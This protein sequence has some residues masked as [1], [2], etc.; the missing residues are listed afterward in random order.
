LTAAGSAT[1]SVS[2]ATGS[3]VAMDALATSLTIATVSEEFAFTA[4]KA[5]AIIDVEADKKTFAS[6]GNAQGAGID[7]ATK[8]DQIVLTLTQDAGT[9]G[10]SITTTAAGVVDVTNAVA[11]V[12]TTADKATTVVT[13]DYSFMDSD[14]VTAG[15]QESANAVVCDN[16]T[17]DVNVSGTELTL[18]DADPVQ[19]QTCYIGNDQAAAM[20]PTTFDGTT[21][22]TYTSAGTTGRTKTYSS[23]LG[24][25][26]LNGASIN[27]Y[28]V[29]FGSTTSRF[30]TVGNKGAGSAVVSATIEY[31]GTAYGPYTLGTLAAKTSSAMGPAIDSA[32]AGAGVT[33][34]DNS[35]AMVT[36]SSPTKANDITVTA[37]YKAIA[38][39][40]RLALPTSDEFE[41]ANK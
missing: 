8:Q 32:L 17:D 39:S 18:T 9:A 4:T 40:D 16:S 19:T 21:T 26:T 36:L 25:W 6:G 30:I 7:D 34:P 5:D 11:Q 35:R 3:G 12:V 2:S 20:S 10:N 22:V 13:G 31:D 33:M 27:V 15:V 14:A 28:G 38:D 41:G 1:V 24:S 23:A 37:A 29:P